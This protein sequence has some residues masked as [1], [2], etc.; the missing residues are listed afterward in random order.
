MKVYNLKEVSV[1]RNDLTSKSSALAVD[2]YHA[3]F[4]MPLLS[5]IEEKELAEE[6]CQNQ[7]VSAAHKLVLAHMRYVVKIAKNYLGYGLPLSELVQEGSVGLMKAV[8]KF[9]PKVGV[10]LVSFAVF[11]IK[12]EMHEFI[13]KNWRTVKIATTKTQR[14][15]FFNLRRLQQKFTQLPS[16]VQHQHI[17]NELD[18]PLSEV[19]SMS[20]RMRSSDVEL[21]KPSQVEDE[22]S[23]LK[24][25]LFDESSSVE[26]QVI[27]SNFQQFMASHLEKAIT[28]LNEREKFI[29]QSRFFDDNK[30]T[31]KDLA[32]QLSVSLERVRQI[33]KSALRKMRVSLT[34]DNCAA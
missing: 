1:I 28:T 20:M 27:E 34:S 30:K 8:K 19:E 13:I 6:F 25:T 16:K 24:D 2:N 32:V 11:W 23:T 22:K 14:K 5:E 26:T 18:L 29:I 15:L 31:L 9:D 17:A 4:S 3:Y 33:E 21:D 12:A 7:S 10:R